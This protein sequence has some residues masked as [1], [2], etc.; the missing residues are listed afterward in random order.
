MHGAIAADRN[1]PV[2]PISAKFSSEN[3][4]MTGPFCWIP[5][6]LGRGAA[7]S[8]SA[9]GTGYRPQCV[10]TPGS[11]PAIGRWIEDYVMCKRAR[12]DCTPYRASIVWMSPSMPSRFS[13]ECIVGR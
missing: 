7:G 9:Q 11:A 13:V 6:H 8:L 1:N 5:V 12:Q 3:G 10:N 4:R 2:G